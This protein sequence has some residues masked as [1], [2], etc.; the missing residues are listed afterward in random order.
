MLDVNVSLLFVFWIFVFKNVLW[1]DVI[2]NVILGFVF[3]FVEEEIVRWVV[4][5]LV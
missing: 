4:Y 2:W 1:E 5:F 3:R